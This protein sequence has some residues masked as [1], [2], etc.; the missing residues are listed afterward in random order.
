VEFVFAEVHLNTGPLNPK[1]RIDQVK[2]IKNYFS[3]ES[4]FKDIPIFIGG[5]F[6]DDTVSAPIDVMEEDYIDLCQVAA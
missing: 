5:D 4:K 6:N 2:Q 1:Q 3:S